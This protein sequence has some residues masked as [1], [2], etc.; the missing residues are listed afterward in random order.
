LSNAHPEA[1]LPMMLDEGSKYLSGSFEKIRDEINAAA[2]V[3]GQLRSKL[4][5]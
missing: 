5:Q 2:T 3:G 4:R 1:K